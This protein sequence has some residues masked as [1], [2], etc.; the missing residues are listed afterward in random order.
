VQRNP[1]RSS[2][3]EESSLH[4]D[5]TQDALGRAA[6]EPPSSHDTAH[7]CRMTGHSEARMST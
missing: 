4:G 7:D 5:A 1:G 3:G 2:L 6:G